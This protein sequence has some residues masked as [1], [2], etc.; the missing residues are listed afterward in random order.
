MRCFKKLQGCK[1][2]DNLR[3]SLNLKKD[4]GEGGPVTL[5]S[6]SVGRPFGNKK[7]K[8][9]RS[10]ALALTT[11]DAS[12]EKMVSCFTAEDKGRDERGAAVWKTMLDKQDIKIG[13]DN[14]KVEAAKMEA[15]ASM[16]KAMNEASTIALAKI[17]QEAKI[18]MAD[19]SNMDSLARVWHEMCRERIGKEVVAAQG[20]AVASTISSV[21]H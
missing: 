18:L 6:A 10:V 9:E 17:T 21:V 14:E 2:W 15:H 4:D 12:I 5:A 8:A 11:I 1:K 19:M 7:T 3:L 13:L 20:A 16:M